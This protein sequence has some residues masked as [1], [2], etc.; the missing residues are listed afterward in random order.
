[1]EMSVAY[2]HWWFPAAICNVTS[3]C[4]SGY[5]DRVIWCHFSRF[6]LRLPTRAHSVLWHNMVWQGWWSLTFHL[7]FHSLVRFEINTWWSL[8][9]DT[10][11][12][13]YQDRVRANRFLSNVIT[14]CISAQ[15]CK[16]HTNHAGCSRHST[17][18]THWL[19]IKDGR[20]HGDAN[21]LAD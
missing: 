14:W 19:Y 12:P 20:S 4:S 6:L 3:V 2:I 11:R 8:G 18:E 9:K 15:T 10:H 7:H 21:W 16:W 5:G 13:S 17:H 1:M